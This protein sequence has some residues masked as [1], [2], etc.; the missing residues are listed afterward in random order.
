MG[1]CTARGGISNGRLRNACTLRN[2]G[3]GFWPLSAKRDVVSQIGG[4]VAIFLNHRVRC[5]EHAPAVFALIPLGLEANSDGTKPDGDILYSSRVGSPRPKIG[6]VLAALRTGDDPAPHLV[7]VEFRPV[8][9]SF[10]RVYHPTLYLDTRQAGPVSHR[11]QMVSFNTLVRTFPNHKTRV[12]YYRARP[13]AAKETRKSYKHSRLPLSDQT[14]PHPVARPSRFYRGSKGPI[15]HT[16]ICAAAWRRKYS[17]PILVRPSPVP[18]T[19]IAALSE[20]TSRAFRRFVYSP[21]PVFTRENV[22]VILSYEATILTTLQIIRSERWQR[23]STF[24]RCRRW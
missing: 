2:V 14:R 22:A 3:V 18:F 11:G 9:Y 7:P 12:Q 21:G 8:G 13:W 19:D 5:P 20:V 4:D 1:A 17:S 10:D 23:V 15:L 24:H 16:Q 6:F